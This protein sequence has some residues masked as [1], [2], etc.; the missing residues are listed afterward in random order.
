MSIIYLLLLYSFSYINSY[1]YIDTPLLLK[2]NEDYRATKILAIRNDTIWFQ[3]ENDDFIKILNNKT[4]KVFG[5]I[6]KEENTN[7]SIFLYE[8]VFYLV[9]GSNNLI[10]RFIYENRRWKLQQSYK[11]NSSFFLTV[12]QSN[13]QKIYYLLLKMNL[14]TYTFDIVSQNNI[15]KSLFSISRPFPKDA[16]FEIPKYFIEEPYLVFIANDEINIYSIN[17]LIKSVSNKLGNN[18]N[19]LLSYKNNRYIVILSNKNRFLIINVFDYY[20]NKI[21]RKTYNNIDYASIIDVN[22]KEDDL[23]LLRYQNSQ[24]SIILIKNFL[25]D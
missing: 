1:S 4:E 6:K 19:R 3:I 5:E 2:L 23:L 8:S 20:I 12:L 21:K 13:L 18:R 24:Y 11:R 14:K 25:D 10:E 9:K 17:G 15:N 16:K 22:I 7:F